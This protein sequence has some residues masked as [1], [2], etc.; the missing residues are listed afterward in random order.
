MTNQSRNLGTVTNDA[1]TSRSTTWADANFTWAE[2][3]GTW[4]NPHDLG[5]QTR[6][7]GTMTNQATS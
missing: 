2:G 6:N 4:D 1:L 3:G 7:L 5:N